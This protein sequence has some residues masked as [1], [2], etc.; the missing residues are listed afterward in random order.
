MGESVA[1]AS[2]LI[3]SFYDAVTEPSAWP[4]AMQALVRFAG[5][6]AGGFQV[7][8]LAPGLAMSQ[9]WAGL[10]PSFERAYVDHYFSQDPW[11]A[12]VEALETGRVLTSREVLPDA[13]LRRTAFYNEL[14]RPYA[15]HDLQCG[16]LERSPS[17]VLGFGMFRRAGASAE[18]EDDTRRRLS[19]ALPHLA[20][21]LK[22]ALR[23][24]QEASARSAHELGSPTRLVSLHVD[25][26]LR[27]LAGDLDAEAKLASSPLRIEQGRLQVAGDEAGAIALARA[28]SSATLGASHTV[29]LFSKPESPVRV[30]VSPRSPNPLLPEGRVAHL[31]VWMPDDTRALE[32][33]REAY[34]LTRVEGLVALRVA[35]GRDL[36]SIASELGISYHTVRVHLRSTFAKTGVGRQAELAALLHGR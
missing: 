33:L 3:A 23:L 22:L 6:A 2:E 30:V 20:R 10:E 17:L 27:V 29:R 5:G 14:C 36:F 26:G 1:G 11:F 21:A 31:L 12:A 28:V 15:L 9:V 18:T 32:A 8:R 35:R 19:L 25:P 4:G 24:E 16:V 7:R 34:R 13:E